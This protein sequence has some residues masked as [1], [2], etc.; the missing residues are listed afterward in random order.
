MKSLI[1]RIFDIVSSLIV[2]SALFPIF[3]VVG[4]IILLES[5]GG[6]F[7]SQM[8]VGKDGSEF[9]LLKFRSMNINADKEG[10]LTVGNDKRITP[11]GHFIRKSKIDEFP[12]LLNIL[13]GDM[14]VVGPRPE[15]PKYVKLYNEEQRKVLT[16]RPGLTDIATIEYINEQQQ[17]GESDDPEKLYIEKIMPDKLKLNLK[18]IDSQSFE[19]DILIIFRTI[20]K[21]F[22]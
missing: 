7:Y 11:F 16:V 10:Q 21:I 12:Q 5:R 4:I 13:I 9:N 20:G 18:Y 14:S 8:R 3:I 22:K 17:L 1:K 6:I 15:V 2:L 19:N